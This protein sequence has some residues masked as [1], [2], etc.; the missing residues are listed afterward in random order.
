MTRERDPLGK[1][2]LF[3]DSAAPEPQG[4]KRGPLDVTVKCAACDTAATLSAPEVVVT[5]LPVLLWMPW[6]KHP[7]LMRCP[8]CHRLAWHS[9]TRAG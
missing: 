4:R 9:V 1:R 3:S 8:S 5:R 7:L 6:R 2:A